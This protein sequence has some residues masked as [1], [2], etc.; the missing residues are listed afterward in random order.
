[1]HIFEK[2]D[3]RMCQF[4]KCVRRKFACSFPIRPRGKKIKNVPKFYLIWQELGSE[5]SI[6]QTT[7]R[8]ESFSQVRKKECSPRTLTNISFEQNIPMSQGL[9]TCEASVLC[10]FAIYSFPVCASF[11]DSAESSGADESISRWKPVFQ[12]IDWNELKC[13]SNM[14]IWCLNY[15][16]W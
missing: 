4:L 10:F 14:E 12:I 15:S 13:L 6:I 1:M 7:Q 16:S 5:S 8:N 2:W 3:N 9:V 11:L